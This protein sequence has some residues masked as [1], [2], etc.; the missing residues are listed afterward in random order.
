MGGVDGRRRHA[1]DPGRRPRTAAASM[2]G[3]GVTAR[4]LQTTCGVHERA[5]GRWTAACSAF[6]D[7]EATCSRERIMNP[8]SKRPEHLHDE[9]LSWGFRNSGF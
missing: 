1:A 5:G 7:G 3:G 8:T 6:W 4:V 2:D 9:R